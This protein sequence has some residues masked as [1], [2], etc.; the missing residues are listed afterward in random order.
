[1]KRRDILKSAVAGAA[2]LAAPRIARAESQRVLKFIPQA[3][4]AS[5]DPIWTTADV[6]RNH[7]FMVFDTLYGVDNKYMPHPQMA[8][9]HTVSTDGKQWD[10]TLRDGLKF[11]DNT[12]VLARDCVASLQRWMKRDA[13]GASIA[14]RLDALEASDDRTLVWRL[15]KPFAALP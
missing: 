11:H 4:L 1:M 7:G 5:I 14:E 2:V 6:T 10:I 8:A 9:G 15:K 3:D 13:I 12:P